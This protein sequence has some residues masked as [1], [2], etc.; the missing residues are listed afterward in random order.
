MPLQQAYKKGIISAKQLDTF[1]EK[2]F[3]NDQDN[4]SILME[5]IH[6]IYTVISV[7][8]EISIQ[9]QNQQ[10][11][12]DIVNSVFNT[13]VSRYNESLKNNFAELS[14]HKIILQENERQKKFDMNS[15]I[16]D[17]EWVILKELQ[18][19]GLEPNNSNENVDSDVT[20]VES[21]DDE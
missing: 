6:H 15:S 10:V 2:S 17:D 7:E 20:F 11:L 3:E 14:K 9:S 19:R 1:L 8:E 4:G 16:S 13:I 12:K 5:N 18:K 21:V